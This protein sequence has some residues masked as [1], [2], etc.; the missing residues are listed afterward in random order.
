MRIG[1]P[2]DWRTIVG[3]LVAG[4]I[5][6]ALVQWIHLRDLD[7][8]LA[9]VLRVGVESEAADVIVEELGRIPV[10]RG[11]GHDGQYFYL[12]ARDPWATKGYADL[13]DDGGYRFRRPLYGWLA[14]G[15]GAFN[16]EATLIGLNVWAILGLGLATAA[17][18]DVLSRLGGK[19]WGMIGVLANLGLWLSVQ[20]VTADA[21]ATGL[22]LLAVSLALRERTAWAALA[23]T[24]AA[25]SKETFV[26]FALGLAVWKW[27]ERDRRTALVYLA[28]PAMGLGAWM[29]WLNAQVGGALSS[30]ANFSLPLVGLVQSFSSW[31]NGSEVAHAVV[32]GAALAIGATGAFVARNRMVL[33]LTIPWVAV[34]FVSS[35]TVWSGANNAVR[36][37]LPAWLLGWIGWAVW[38]SRRHDGSEAA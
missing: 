1:R 24:G 14:G 11:T 18:A 4:L 20:L 13:A 26:L 2:S 6:G 5:I 12:I 22:A 36:A 21:L 23:L 9:G 16:P 15:F 35:S 38:S 19:L 32:A 17:T 29:I 30:K 37:F 28:V 7:G 33:W 25:L 31:T 3:W 8:N 10:T 27:L 34:A